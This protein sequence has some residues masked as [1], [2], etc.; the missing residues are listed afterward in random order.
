M[1]LVLLDDGSTKPIED[2]ELGDKIT[3]TD[4]ETGET[5]VRE[6]V[7]TIVTEDDKHFVDLT[8]KGESGVPA[9]LVSTTTHPFWSVSEGRWIDAGDLTPGMKLRT[10]DGDVVEISGARYFEKRLRTHD[11]T[12]SEIHTYYVLAGIEP[13]LV[14]NCGK[15]DKDH[16]IQGAHPKDH[17]DLTDAQL[18]ARAQN[19][20]NTNVAS[21]LDSATAQ[22]H[23]DAVVEKHRKAINT[24]ATSAK[25]STRKEFSMNLGTKI[26]RVAD[27]SGNV[28]DATKP[29][30]V[31]LRINGGYQGHKGSWVLLT[32]KAS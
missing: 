30:L 4:P 9:A 29:T 2:V 8:I 16:G 19:D 11:L 15:L 28:R 24:W 26:G 12:V 6:V 32:V 22:Q 27:S 21:M 10:P 31:L 5:V 20:P 13:V 23:I 7:G 3:V 17:L 18:R 14:H 25:V 1:T